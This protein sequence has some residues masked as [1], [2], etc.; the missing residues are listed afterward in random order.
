[1]SNQTDIVTQLQKLPFISD[2]VKNIINDIYQY[3][4]EMLNNEKHHHHRQKFIQLFDEL[5]R[6]LK[7]DLFNMKESVYDI[8]IK[9]LFDQ[10]KLQLEKF[11]NTFSNETLNIEQ[12]NSIFLE[13]TTC[14]ER[15][16]SIMQTI[17]KRVTIKIN[18]GIEENEKLFAEIDGIKKKLNQYEQLK[19]QIEELKK[20][21]LQRL[22]IEKYHDKRILIHDLFT[23]LEEKLSKQLQQHNIPDEKIN[24]FLEPIM[25]CNTL[26]QYHPVLHNIL[27]EISKDF[28]L[29]CD[30]I[31]FYL[32][33]KKS[34]ES[35]HIDMDFEA[36]ARSREDSQTYILNEFLATMKMHLL[37]AQDVVV[38]QPVFEKVCR[39]IN[40]Q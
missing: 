20:K 4:M 7:N 32:K 34:N 38:L 10:T 11:K 12:F 33:E 40:N 35:F 13:L 23:I 29:T 6:S 16:Y 21:D 31:M 27:E 24:I 3:E 15:I 22:K 5:L 8:Q 9:S 14:I 30:Q 1:M 36:Y 28:G 39:I 37:D 26:S 19:M 25:N 18:T 2:D 17:F